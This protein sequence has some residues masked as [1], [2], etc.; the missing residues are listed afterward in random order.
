MLANDT[1][2]TS[3]HGSGLV[4]SRICQEF[5]SRGMAVFSIPVDT[6]W[7]AYWRRIV[8]SRGVVMNGEGSMH[9]DAAVARELVD[10]GAFCR[11]EGIH[12]FLV[13]S[14]WDSNSEVITS[15]LRHLNGV[16]VRDSLSQRE[17][18]NSGIT[19]EVSPD[20]SLAHFFPRLSSE[21]AGRTLVIDS[22]MKRTSKRLWQFHRMT[23]GSFFVSLYGWVPVQS[24][25]TNYL[26]AAIGYA[27]ETATSQIK[28]SAARRLGELLNSPS[29]DRRKSGSRHSRTTLVSH[30][31][32]AS[33]AIIGRYHGV[34]LAIV[35]RTPFLAVPSNSNK[36]EALLADIGLNHRLIDESEL[37]PGL[38]I[39]PFEDYEQRAIDSF[40]LDAHRRQ[41]Q[42]FLTILE[43][44]S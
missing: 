25:A 34:C 32:Q 13:N 10:L 33:G 27:I 22:V 20:L 7:R 8:G 44:I 40:L 11:T 37:V 21:K 5:K 19:A 29:P 42:M 2:V 23:Q 4:V 12:C 31:Q 39:P 1:S 6:S 41:E 35:T 9:H 15:Q 24:G 30:F 43:T 38:V 36:V 17:L 28:Q 18:K 26:Q 3:H 16:W 14:T